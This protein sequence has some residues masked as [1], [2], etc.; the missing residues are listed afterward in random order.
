MSV[1]FHC[2]ILYIAGFIQRQHSSAYI[3]ALEILFMMLSVHRYG[4]DHHY[5]LAKSHDVTVN[6]N[7]TMRLQQTIVQKEQDQYSN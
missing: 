3:D 6:E 2:H 1:I 4:I 5:R 7:M